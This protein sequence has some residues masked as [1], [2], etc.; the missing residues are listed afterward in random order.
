MVEKAKEERAFP[1]FPFG[2]SF[3]CR[4]RFD[5]HNVLFGMYLCYLLIDCDVL[6]IV[7]CLIKQR[8]KKQIF[9][10]SN[11]FSQRKEKEAILVSS[12]PFTLPFIPFASTSCTN[13]FWTSLS[14]FSMPWRASA[15]SR[16]PPQC[17]LCVATERQIQRNTPVVVDELSQCSV[18]DTHCPPSHS[19]FPSPCVPFTRVTLSLSLS[20]SLLLFFSSSLLLSFSP[21]LLL[22][23][24]PV[25]G[26]TEGRCRRR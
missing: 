4:V 26:D 13:A 12:L 22:L 1:Y 9:L 10:L 7:I 11:K 18:N 8:I 19:V 5:F 25:Y 6:C 3:H 14:V 16:S 17:G 21:S 20:P 15:T 23:S 24:S 2:Q